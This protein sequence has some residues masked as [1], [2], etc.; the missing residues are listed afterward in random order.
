[1]FDGNQQMLL[2]KAEMEHRPSFGCVALLACL[3]LFCC[4]VW[5]MLTSQDLHSCM[6][7]LYILAT[8]PAPTTRN[9]HLNQILSAPD[10][11]KDLGMT[12]NFLLICLPMSIVSYAAWHLKADAG[13]LMV[14]GGVFGT[15]LLVLYPILLFNKSY[16]SG[17][18]DFCC[19]RAMNWLLFAA[20]I[21]VGG[22]GAYKG[23]R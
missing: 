6:Q 15:T 4:L 10:Y 20:A 2:A 12:T 13:I 14:A 9:S 18:Q 16:G 21:G 1:M 7:R 23:V 11:T 19:R 8:R 17:Q 5:F 3:L 22:F